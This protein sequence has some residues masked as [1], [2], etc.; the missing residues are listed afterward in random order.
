[1]PDPNPFEVEIG[2]AKFKKHKLPGGDQ[3]QALLFQAVSETLWSE[4]HKL[5]NL[6]W[7]K[8][9]LPVQWNEANIV[10]IYKNGDKNLTIVII[11]KYH[12]YQVHAEFYPV[13]FFF[14]VKSIY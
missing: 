7:S 13:S 12:C 4:I 2:I 5:I 1:V 6:I 10:R 14:K 9:E 8:E 3:I 11:K